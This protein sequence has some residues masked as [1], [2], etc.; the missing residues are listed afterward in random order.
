MIA[1]VDFDWLRPPWL[2]ALLLLI[3]GVLLAWRRSRAAGWTRVVDAHLLPHLL[4]PGHARRGVVRAAPA[5]LA[6]ALAVLAL[7]G[8]SVGRAPAPAWQ[9]RMPL[10]I[11]LDLSSAAR[12]TDIAPNR[13]AIA[14]QSIT[15]ALRLRAG[16]PVA[17]VAF[18]GA[19]FTVA[20]LT[21]DAANVAVFLDA[22]SPDVMPLDGRRT[23]AALR[24]AA[25][26]L[27]RA[28]HARGRVLLMSDGADANA[29]GAAEALQ[30][31]GIR[32]DVL[33]IGGEAGA[34]LRTPEGLRRVRLDAASLQAL[35]RAGGGRYAVATTGD[36]DLRSL[37]VADAAA[38]DGV[39]GTPRGQARRDDGI[40]LVP[41]VLLLVLPAFRRRAGALAMLAVVALLP[42]QLRASE[43]W[44]RADQAAHARMVEGHRDY[45]AGRF[46]AAAQAYAGVSGADAHYNR[47]NALAKAGHYAPA[48]AAYDDAL[49]LQPGMADAIANRDAVRRAMQRNPPPGRGQRPSSRPGAGARNAQGGQQTQPGGG[50]SRA[51]RPPTPP[52]DANAQARADAALREQQRRAQARASNSPV[53]SPG[54]APR[55]ARRETAAER[56]QRLANEAALRRVPDDPGA[57]LRAKFQ[58]EYERR[59]REGSA[60]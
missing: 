38:M 17:L 48:V 37:G 42:L 39:A 21:D 30:A 46:D 32:V 16:A 24:H 52:R 60:P 14:R 50:T 25:D 1:A 59:R 28:G 36:G 51:S 56:Q 4:E 8:P 54:G 41:A 47:G 26:L 22:L 29:I 18:S 58:L 35:A 9:V 11:V 3:P 2:W 55:P 23:D 13:L 6:Y 27:A 40:W 44:R 33:G 57:L 43:L 34:L 19:P 10:V 20:P 31:T 7:A 12:A 49:R 15:D 5:L 53:R 45:R